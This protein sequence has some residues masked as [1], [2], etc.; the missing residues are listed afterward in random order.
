MVVDFGIFSQLKGLLNL[1]LSYLNTTNTADL[2][3]FFSHLKSLSTL[4]L[5]GQRVST[6]KMGPL[7]NLP[8]HLGRLLLPGCGITEFPNFVRNLQQMSNLD[9]SNNQIKGQVPQWLWKLPMLMTINLSSNSFTGL[10]RSSNHFPRAEIIMLNLSSNAFQGPLVIPPVSTEAMLV[11]NNNFTGKIPRS[12][13]GHRYLSILDLSNNNFSGSIP[14]CLRNLNDYLTVINLGYNQLSGNIPEIFTNATELS[15]FDVSHNR[16]VGTLPRSLKSCSSLEV[17]N[18]GS[19]EIEDTFPFW[20][21]SLPNLKVMVLR[22]NKFNGLLHRP[23]RSFGY[24]KLQIIDI[25]KNHFTG[26]LPTY[27]FAEWNMTTSKDFKGFRYI[28]KDSSYYHDSIVLTSKGVEMKLERIFTL[29][30]AIDFSGN[31]LQGKIPESIGLLK[32]LIVLNFSSNGFTGNIPPSLANLTELESLDLSHNKLSGQIPPALGT[33]TSLSSITVSHNN[34]VGPIPQS[35]QIQTQDASSFE[36]NIQ[37]CG[38]PLS[39]KCG[40]VDT[41]SEEEEEEEEEVLSWVAA[42]MALGPGFIFGLTIGITQNPQM[43]HRR[44]G[45]HS[46]SNFMFFGSE[47]AT[48]MTAPS[49]LKSPLASIDHMSVQLQDHDA[50]KMKSTSEC[51]SG[52]CKVE[53]DNR[54]NSP[55]SLVVQPA[56]LK[57]VGFKSY[58]D[59]TKGSDSSSRFEAMLV[60]AT[61]LVSEL[62]EA[63]KV[64]GACV[65]EQLGSQFQERSRPS[66]SKQPSQH[67]RVQSQM[68]DGDSTLQWILQPILSYL[69][70]RIIFYGQVKLRNAKIG[71]KNK[72]QNPQAQSKKDVQA[73]GQQQSQSSKGEESVHEGYVLGLAE[74]FVPI[75]SFVLYQNRSSA[76]CSCTL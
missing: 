74:V 5:S 12:I 72:K 15:S 29:L 41:E 67:T 66:S 2:S 58:V 26:N 65:G 37:L 17:F 30:T 10:E 48:F 3:I 22:N 20:L 53:P 40:D 43:V 49:V 60:L 7:S 47:I 9:L 71:A 75:G 76:A 27:Y 70:S 16:L 34:L 50:S 63:A 6:A 54:T 24:P 19:N 32:N 55:S 46:V 57:G 21:N 31:R 33:L 23:R 45:T 51:Y 11:S 62:Q 44:S 8:S 28:G 4:D 18:V 25:A 13:C 1:D 68:S 35:T 64:T 56:N 42:A 36:G 14:Q 38:L 59:P 69:I 39:E 61:K 73:R 52:T